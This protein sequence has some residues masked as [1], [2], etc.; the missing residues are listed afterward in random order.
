MLGILN[1]ANAQIIFVDTPGWLKP[2]DTFQSFMKRAINRAIYDDAD[3]LVWVVEPQP[4]RRRRDDVRARAAANRAS[5]WSPSSTRATGAP[6]RAVGSAW[7]RKFTTVLGAKAPIFRV[8][9][10]TGDGVEAVREQALHAPARI[11]GLFSRGPDHRQ[12]GAL[13]RRGAHPRADLPAVTRK[14]CRTPPPWWW[15]SSLSARARRTTS[16]SPFT[17]KPRA[18]WASSSGN[19]GAAIKKLGQAGPGGDRGAPGTAGSPRTGGEGA[20]NWRKDADF[21]ESLRATIRERSYLALDLCRLTEM[22]ARCFNTPT[23]QRGILPRPQPSVDRSRPDGFFK[24]RKL[25][26]NL[27][28]CQLWQTQF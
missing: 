28:R 3:V 11:A 17:S 2:Q 9:A 24:R 26:V 27:R 23:F 10:Q 19:K 15:K 6:R 22:N 4:S 16:R 14:K 25:A 13:L 1:W 18:S 5:R 20:Q 12:V 7:K 8:S 21:L